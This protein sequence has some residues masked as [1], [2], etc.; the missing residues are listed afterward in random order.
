MPRVLEPRQGPELARGQ[1]HP[2]R[3]LPLH[4]PRLG[5]ELASVAVLRLFRFPGDRLEK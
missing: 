2:T 3:R 5:G 4:G 1:R